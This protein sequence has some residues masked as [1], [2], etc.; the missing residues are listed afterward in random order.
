MSSPAL[1]VL[2]DL[3]PGGG[4]AM[5]YAAS[6]AEALQARLVL[7]HLR[8]DAQPTPAEHPGQ[9]TRRRELK[10]LLALQN[11]AS[12]QPVPASIVVLGDFLPEAVQGIVRQQRPWALVLSTPHAGAAPIEVVTSTALDL[13]RHSHCPLL[14]L[15]PGGAPAFA[16]R[17]LLL[18]VD[19]HEFTLPDYPRLVPELLARP[20]ATLE[21]L[22]VTDQKDPGAGARHRAVHSVRH[23]GLAPVPEGTWTNVVYHPDTAQGILQGAAERHADLLVLVARHHSL[24]GSLFH[25]SV[26]AQLIEARALP[27]LLVPALN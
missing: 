20:G 17:R 2:P 13:L 19:G 1:L 6:L 26:T 27:L 9:H 16:P 22:F 14:V 12:Q 24:L 21:L 18:A 8:Q 7:L 10:S 4:Q 5:P 25:R 15:P 23:S 3:F 11:L